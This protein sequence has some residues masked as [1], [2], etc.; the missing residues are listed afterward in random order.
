MTTT[1]Y[2]KW[3]EEALKQ[4]EQAKLIPEHKLQQ[5]R[6][7]SEADAREKIEELI[8][9]AVLRRKLKLYKRLLK[10]HRSLDIAPYYT[11]SIA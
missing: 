11:G 8:V 7:R 3:Y 5:R 6:I 9:V 2:Q 4:I 1:P 10:M